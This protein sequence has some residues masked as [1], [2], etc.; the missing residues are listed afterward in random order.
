MGKGKLLRFAALAAVAAF[1]GIMSPTHAHAFGD[2][3]KG[4]DDTI[5]IENDLP[6]C[7]ITGTCGQSPR[8]DDRAPTTVPTP[9]GNPK[10]PGPK[11]KTE[12][13]CVQDMNDE[14]K[15]AEVDKGLCM[16]REAGRAGRECT[17]EG[18]GYGRVSSYD[19]QI[20]SH[21]Y[22]TCQD[23]WRE[24]EP[25]WDSMCCNWVGDSCRNKYQYVG[26]EVFHCQTFT[27]EEIWY[28]QS[29]H[30][31][32]EE[33]MIGASDE[34]ETE[35]ETS[36]T[37]VGGGLGSHTESKST[38]RWER[39]SGEGGFREICQNGYRDA[40]KEAYDVKRKCVREA[41]K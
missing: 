25:G 29:W 41:R 11:K 35:T 9:S 8:K 26:A 40:A 17:R 18:E 10:P 4:D 16:N 23:T 33:K 30:D 34:T 37:Q 39:G 7:T 22:T 28:P 24:G 12:A 13:Q 6:M 2:D 21:E 15:D 14:L 3:E 31:C 38:S 20:C 27:R 1:A 19:E 32:V 36:S 5:V